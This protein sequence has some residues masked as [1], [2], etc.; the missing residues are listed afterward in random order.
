MKNYAFIFG[1]EIVRQF[2]ELTSS[3]ASTRLRAIYPGLLL[4]NS[5]TRVHLLHASDIE[6]IETILNAEQIDSVVVG[7]VFD[8]QYVPRLVEGLRTA[9]LKG[10]K[11]VL[12]ICDY[13]FSGGESAD[14][15]N[16]LISFCDRLV[17]NTEQMRSRVL[18]LNSLIG[19][20]V[21]P[22]PC[23]IDEPCPPSTQI[24]DFNRVVVFGN[25]KNGE[26][27]HNQIIKRDSR[28]LETIHFEYH[29]M[30]DEE[31]VDWLVRLKPLYHS[32]SVSVTASLWNGTWIQSQAL[33]RS[34]VAYLPGDTQSASS[35][36]KSSNRLLICIMLGVPTIT[37]PQPSYLEFESPS[38]VVNDNFWEAHE[39]LKS[40]PLHQ[41][42]S[43]IIDNQQLV[44]QRY[45]KKIVAN[46][47]RQ[48]LE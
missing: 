17:V 25:K 23:E 21:I 28:C 7:K 44:S 42:H 34:G 30:I 26:W 18:D 29:G 4:A 3:A 47:W 15:Q 33:K 35:M 12:D 6:K 19:V 41:I 1:T 38:V 10:T 46:L 9:K 27:L 32:K 16:A 40:T 20:D 24:I 37:Y 39:A 14:I 11:I 2:G 31:I 5:D 43:S 45:S 13:S 8:N 36:T 22:D 48:V